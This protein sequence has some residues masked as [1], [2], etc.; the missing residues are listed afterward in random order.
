MYFVHL[1]DF[2]A[3]KSQQHNFLH[4]SQLLTNRERDWD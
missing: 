2:Y 1:I 3:L 4:G